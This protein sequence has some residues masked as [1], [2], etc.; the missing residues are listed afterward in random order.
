MADGYRLVG[1]VVVTRTISWLYRL[2]D[3]GAGCGCIGPLRDEIQRLAETVSGSSQDAV[4]KLAIALLDGRHA[5]A[6]ALTESMAGW[7]TVLKY[8]HDAPGLSDRLRAEH[9]L[10]RSIEI[11]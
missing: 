5:D 2:P 7:V 4:L 6:I 8:W 3:A 1:L 9:V 11:E 10:V